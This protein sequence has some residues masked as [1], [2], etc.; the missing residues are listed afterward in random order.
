MTSKVS[1]FRKYSSNVLKS[2]I[3]VEIEDSLKAVIFLFPPLLK[4]EQNDAIHVY[5]ECRAVQ[6]VFT[7]VINE[8][9]FQPKQKE[10]LT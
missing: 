8:R 5:S 4:K 10:T 6:S 3:F 9:V 7:H 1:Y 2:L